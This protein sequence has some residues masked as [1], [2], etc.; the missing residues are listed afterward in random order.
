[1]EKKR[2]YTTMVFPQ[3][4]DGTTLHLNIVV[5]PRNQD[6]F[7]NH[8]TGLPAPDNTAVPFADLVPQFELKVVKGLDEW[9]IGNALALTR[10]PVDVPVNV[11]AATNKNALLQAI[12]AELGAKINITASDKTPDIMPDSPTV[13]KYLPES[14]R[15]AFNFTSPRVPNAKTDDSYHCAIKKDTPLVA[16]WKNND[17]LSWGQVFA[18][19]LRQPLLARACGM[20]YETEI[21]VEGGNAALFEKGCYIYADIVNEDYKSIQEKL[22]VDADGPFIKPY[23]ARIPKLKTGAE[24]KRPVFAP[25]LFPVLFVKT[26][27]IVDPEPPAAPWDKIFAELNEY[28]D[29]FAKIVHAAQPVSTILLSERQDG[30]H[31]VKDEGIRLAWDDEQILIWYMRQL[32]GYPAKTGPRVDAPLGVFGYRIDVKEDAL[33]AD[34]SSLNL[35][36][37][38]QTYSLGGASLGNAA[39]EEL[40]LPFQVFPTQLDNDTKAPYWLP[41]YFTSWIGKSVVLKDSDAVNIHQSDE[42]RLNPL[43]PTPTKAVDP[44][45]MFDEVAAATLLRYGNRYQFRVRMMD[46]SGGGPVIAEDVYNNAAAPTSEWSFKRYVAPSLCRIEKSKD[47]REAKA[48]FFNEII[49]GDQTSSFNSNPV[50]SIQRPVLNYPAVVFTGKYQSLGA[51]PVQLLIQS[52]QDQKQGGTAANPKNIVPAI[53]DPD[54]AEV[55]IKVEV[56]TLRLDNL[57]SESGNE[58]YITLYTTSRNFPAVNAA[59]DMEDTLSLN[60]VFHDAPTLN[61]GSSDDPFNTPGLNKAA[62]NAMTDIPLPTARKIRMTIRAVCEGE[63]STYYGFINEANPDLDSRYGKKTQFWFYKELINEDAPLLLPKANVPALQGLYLQPD[64]EFIRKG[65]VNQFFFFNAETSNRPDIMQRLAQQLGVKVN[66]LTLV[67][68]KGE[69]VVFGCNNKI[70]HHLAPDGSSIT[71]STKADLCNHWIGCLVYRLNRD[72]SWDG[73]QDTAFIIGRQKKFSRDDAGETETLNNIGDIEIKHSASFESLQTDPFGNINRSSSTIIFIDAIEPKSALLQPNGQ[74]RFPDKIEVQ[75]TI[76]AKFKEGH[77]EDQTE[78]PDKLIL[79]ATVIPAQVP[80]IASVG[81]AFSPYRKNEKYSA[82]EARQ[83]YLWVELEEPVQNPADT[84]FCR[85]LH[86]APDQLIGNNKQFAEL[87]QAT[88]EDPPLPIDPEYIRMITPGQTDDM[89]GLGAMQAMEK[90]SDDDNI[91]Y[92]LPLPPGLHPESPELFGFFTYE[93]RIGHGH[94]SNDEAGKENLWSTAQG[95]FGRPLVIAGMQHPAPTLLCNVNRDIDKVYVNAPY[96]KAVWKGKNVTNDPP[97]TQLHCILYAQVKQAD[98]TTYRNIL[99]DEKLMTLVRPQQP[100]V[101][102]PAGTGLFNNAVLSEIVHTSAIW[103]VDKTDEAARASVVLSNL[104]LMNEINRLKIDKVYEARLNKAM[105]DYKSGKAVKIDKTMAA[106][107]LHAFENLKDTGTTAPLPKAAKFTAASL[108]AGAVKAIYKDQPKTAT[109]MWANKEIAVL[110]K[111]LGLPEDAPLSVLV[112]EVFGNITS[113]FDH[114]LPLPDERLAAL[115]SQR[116]TKDLAAT[117]LDRRNRNRQALGDE[118][119]NYRIL[120]TSPLTE[121]PFVCCPTC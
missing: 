43:D 4:Y 12:A 11:D 115:S 25:I 9:P 66:G 102:T 61:L 117:L 108:L 111:Q 94:W 63:D 38:K 1:M 17:D 81:L 87:L 50:L 37:S 35:V 45:N 85:V 15:G 29:G 103:T 54:V 78:Q 18:Y 33:N 120:R 22:M 60:V 49:A 52:A 86:Y 116:A 101:Q 56:E 92:L 46:I 77:G 34:W 104:T 118:L 2:R 80:K 59:A 114:F 96:A 3:G 55:E 36:R 113:I 98:G 13:N 31:P 112:V 39:N 5:I 99:L 91:H 75:Y 71:F 58:N 70:R 121:V 95:R 7:A 51:D 32:E 42:A 72:W 24:N 107:I 27:E 119:G 74:L 110:L 28:N 6:P 89:A 62:I 76:A 73:L 8:P 88:V 90:A 93:F 82:T 48:D 21:T 14:Y 47:L 84:I 41:M 109:A 65:I 106:N 40:E 105:R 79:P 53:A 10:K 30:S 64:P 16:T 57:A 26:G 20:V 44:N 69:R 100:E 83:K 23:A 68:E 67:A 97:R 19:I